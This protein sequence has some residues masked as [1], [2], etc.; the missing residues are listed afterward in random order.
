VLIAAQRQGPVRAQRIASGK[1]STLSPV[2]TETVNPEAV[3]MSDGHHSYKSI[4]DNFADHQSVIHGKREYV[5][6]TVH[7]N[8]AESFGAMLER[9]KEGVFHYISGKHLDRYLQEIS[10]RWNHRIPTEKETKSGKR[11]VTWTPMPVIT[12]LQ[13]VLSSAAGKQ[14]RRIPNNGLVFFYA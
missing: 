12:M 1:I 2:I 11:K 7:V 10:F 6:G 14:K 4:A 9:V 5:R 13:S 8:T 3:I